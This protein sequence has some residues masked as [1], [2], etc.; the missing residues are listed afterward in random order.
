MVVQRGCLAGSL[1]TG[2]G[3]QC[4]WKGGMSQPAESHHLPSQA[5]HRR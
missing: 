2:P 4:V 5:S 3:E 1:Q